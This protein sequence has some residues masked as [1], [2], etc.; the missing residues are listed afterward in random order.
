MRIRASAT[1]EA[2]LRTQALNY[3]TPTLFYGIGAED[4]ATI[5]NQSPVAAPIQINVPAGTS[6]DIDVAMVG[7]EPDGQSMTASVP[8]QPDRGTTAIVV[9]KVRY[10]AP[11][12]VA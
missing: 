8:S 9:N 2:T 10:T 5:A 7:V 1:P 3:L 6:T 4:T 12:P 11:V